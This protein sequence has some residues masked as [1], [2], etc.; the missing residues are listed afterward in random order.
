MADAPR[1]ARNPFKL[2]IVWVVGFVTDP[3]TRATSA[4]KI[5]GLIVTC[6]L[7]AYLVICALKQFK[8]DEGVCAIFAGLITACLALRPRATQESKLP[9]NRRESDRVVAPPLEPHEVG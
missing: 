5:A 2:A 8:P 1:K 6:A 3:H 7:C 4:A 9:S